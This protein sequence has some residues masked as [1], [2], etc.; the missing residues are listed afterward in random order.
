MQ[1][2]ILRKRLSP[3]H[4]LL[5][6]RVWT[7][8]DKERLAESIAE[9]ALGQWMHVDHVLRSRTDQMASEDTYA[10][11]EAIKSLTV[12]SEQT[13]WHRDGWVFQF[14]SWIAAVEAK[15]GPVRAPQMDRASK[16][17]DGI[18]LLTDRSRTRARA[19][20]IFEDKATASPRKT[21]RDDV[22]QSFKEIERGSRDASLSA[23]LSNL[24]AREPK[25]DR[26]RAVNRVF[27]SPKGRRYRVSVTATVTHT[28]HPDLKGLFDGF[29]VAVPGRRSRR[30]ANAL[31]VEDLRAELAALC[32][33]A[34]ELLE[35]RRDCLTP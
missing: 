9:L 19:L 12:P 32:D 22:W 31:E 20:I 8:P 6:G 10:I 23:E 27:R 30:Y 2:V 11:D 4:Q 29:E 3:R 24:L 16:G 35:S 5:K 34:V 17:F 13:S 15:P 1:R 14:I 7:V 25:I 18:Q 26:V 28:A 21:V 33:R